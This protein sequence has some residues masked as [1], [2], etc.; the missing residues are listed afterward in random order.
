MPKRKPKEEAEEGKKSKADRV[1]SLVD[2]VG[3]SLGVRPVK[4]YKGTFVSNTFSSGSLAFDLILGG[5]YG[6]GRW[7]SLYGPS[8]SGKSTLVY[9]A[10]AM[11]QRI[12]CP[13]LLFD[14]EGSLDPTLM[15]E[16][17]VTLHRKAGFFYLP[18]DV[19]ELTFRFIRR[20]LK[21]LPDVTDEQRAKMLKPRM[22]FFID[23]LAAMIA[24][25]VDEDDE[26]ESMAVQAR[27]FSR[28]IPIVRG[29]LFRKGCTVIVTNQIREAPM[30]FGNP[31]REP[32]GN[33]PQFYPDVRVR[34]AKH[35]A[36]KATGGEKQESFAF[37]S[38]ES[39]YRGGGTDKFV[40]TKV[41]TQ[42]NKMFSPFLETE[43][44][45]NL[46]RGLDPIQDGV[47]YLEMT[48][49][50]TGSAGNYTISLD[51]EDKIKAKGWLNL[52]KIV[53]TPEF[54]AKCRE[55]LRSNKA[56]EMFFEVQSG[57]VLADAEKKG[58]DPLAIYSLSDDYEEPDEDEDEE[59]TKR[60]SKKV[61]RKAKKLLK[62]IKKFK[63]GKKG[64]KG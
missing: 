42:K 44:R 59:D 48:G 55:Q 21:Q 7:I 31:E 10:I 16:I 3:G 29:L 35:S 18:A 45:I 26:K 39:L 53:S 9:T 14:H 34:I 20:M 33:A 17:G 57:R 54:R 19:G 46:G 38:E 1:G 30:S 63:K 12:G 4:L 51:G 13:Q 64:K 58:D 25:Q 28:Y 15:Q 49:Q 11:L 5:G 24:Q 61:K 47:S 27:M 60:D 43:L 22:V 6:I 62:A 52:G 37:K 2:D 41:K 50:L 8:G 36:P 56:F 23:S 32:G 40:Y